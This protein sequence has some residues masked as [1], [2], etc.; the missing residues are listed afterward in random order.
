LTLHHR[1]QQWVTTI[2]FSSIGTM[3]S[4]MATP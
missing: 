4:K 1:R 3:V 2:R